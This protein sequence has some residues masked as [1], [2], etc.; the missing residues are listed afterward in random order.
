MFCTRVVIFAGTTAIGQFPGAPPHRR[1]RGTSFDRAP[2]ARCL[3]IRPLAKNGI[4]LLKR[5]PC[6]CFRSSCK[7]PRSRPIM[8]MSSVKI[9]RLWLSFRRQFWLRLPLF[10][11]HIASFQAWFLGNLEVSG[12]T[13][14]VDLLWSPQETSVVS[15]GPANGW[16]GTGFHC[17][18]ATRTKDV[19]CF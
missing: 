8:S 14:W 12:E 16:Y 4:L 10:Y 17:R 18:S 6:L 3:R 11:C 5:H 13:S 9:A 15:V 19:N 2:Y 7:S 1:A